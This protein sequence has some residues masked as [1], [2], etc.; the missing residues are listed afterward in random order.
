MSLQEL[1]SRSEAEVFSC[2]DSK[3]LPGESLQGS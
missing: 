1:E 3:L 2:D